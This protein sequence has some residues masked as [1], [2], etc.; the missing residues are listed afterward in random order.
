MVVYLIQFCKPA[1]V[2]RCHEGSAIKLLRAVEVS[3]AQRTSE[4][5]RGERSCERAGRRLDDLLI[6]QIP[7]LQ[8]FEAKRAEAQKLEEP[9]TPRR[10]RCKALALRRLPSC[11]ALTIRYCRLLTRRWHLRL[12]MLTALTAVRASRSSIQP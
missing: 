6:D 8:E 12:F 5:L 3:P 9:S 10:G 2:P 7:K 4:D 11:H 1:T